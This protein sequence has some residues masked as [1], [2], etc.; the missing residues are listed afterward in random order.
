MVHRSLEKSKNA[1][2]LKT[3]GFGCC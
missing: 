3:H 2:S 1:R